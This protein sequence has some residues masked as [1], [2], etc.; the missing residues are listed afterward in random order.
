MANH[1]HHSND[2]Q[3]RLMA[4]EE[5]SA[6]GADGAE[7]VASLI[8]LQHDEALLRAQAAQMDE[9]ARKIE[10]EGGENSQNIAAQMHAQAGLASSLAA[11]VNQVIN[12][13]RN[14]PSKRVS[15]RKRDALHNSASVVIA[16]GEPEASAGASSHGDTAEHHFELH[17]AREAA[18]HAEAKP[19]AAKAKHPAAHAKS[20]AKIEPAAEVKPHRTPLKEK[21]HHGVEVVKET[22]HKAWDFVKEKT[23]MVG[24]AVGGAAATVWHKTEEVCEK[25]V[26]AVTHPIETAKKVAGK[27]VG[28][29]RSAGSTIRGW[30]TDDDDEDVPVV[31]AP[32]PQKKALPP[33]AVHAAKTAHLSHSITGGAHHDADDALSPNA[34][35]GMLPSLSKL[36]I[37]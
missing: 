10:H 37:S 33:K 15:R 4:K 23:V 25:A 7:Q 1:D 34:W 9:E 27:A 30:F 20:K 13:V 18:K 19:A 22:A 24:A 14:D 5:D 11:E 8:Q 31:V 12:E 28:A 2:L 26:H 36:G 29:L 32:K 21:I 17:E 3:S 16:G 35:M 6:S